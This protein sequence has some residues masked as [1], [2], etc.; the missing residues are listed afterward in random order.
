MISLKF[1]YDIIFIWFSYDFHMIVHMIF[2]W[3]S[4][5]PIENLSSQT[6]GKQWFAISRFRGMFK[7][8]FDLHNPPF[9]ASTSQQ[10]YIGAP[11]ELYKVKELSEF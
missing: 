10:P 11:L 2:L 7:P 9:C 4:Y 1:S 8:H 3:F 6:I 5:W